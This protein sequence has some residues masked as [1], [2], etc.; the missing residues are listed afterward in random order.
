[1]TVATCVGGHSR[2]PS[3][4]AAAEQPVELHLAQ[5]GA[6]ADG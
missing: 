4:I 1:M 6:E 3:S 2:S 5:D